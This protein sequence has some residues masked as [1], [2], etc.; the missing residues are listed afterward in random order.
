MKY[1]VAVDKFFPDI[2]SG[3]ARVAWDI[4]MAVRDDGHDVTVFTRKQSPDMPDVSEIDG[5]RVIKFLQPT[6]STLY[7]FKLR[8]Y[9]RA[10][11][12]AA[13]KYLSGESFDC[14]HNHQPIVYYRILRDVLG[15]DVPQILTSHSPNVM[16]MEIKWAGEGFAGMLKK[17]G[18]LTSLRERER[19]TL[20]GST[21]IHTLSDFNRRQLD[22]IYGVGPKITAVPHWCREGFS[23]VMSKREA[24]DALGWPKG[25][26]IIFCIRR[27]VA[28]MGIDVAIKAMA[29]LV[30][31]HPEARLMLAGDGTLRPKMEQL[32]DSLCIRPWV[33]FLGKIDDEELKRCYEAADIFL[34]PTRALECFGLIILEAFAYGLPIIATDSGAIPEIVL[35]IMPEGVVPAGEVEALRNRLDEFISG[36]LSCPSPHDIM[37]YAADRYGRDRIVPRLLSLIEVSP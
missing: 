8:G 5:V 37:K 16:E 27:F 30:K 26:P 15:A 33:H 19:E 11:T 31:R 32:V 9:E 18:G 12:E 23:R 28:R 22:R 20:E 34:L 21:I 2:P 4:A 36:K 1:L 25:K 3:S 13:R 14:V 35:P 7:P 6:F 17:F 24:R 29:L 10:G